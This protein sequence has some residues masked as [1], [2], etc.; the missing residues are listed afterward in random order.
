MLFDS[1]MAVLIFSRLSANGSAP[2][3]MTARN[4]SAMPSLVIR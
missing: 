3:A 1:G 2:E 4:A